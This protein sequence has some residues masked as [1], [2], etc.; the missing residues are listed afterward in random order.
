L[1][2]LLVAAINPEGPGRDLKIVI[3][4]DAASIISTI[5][6]S[7]PAILDD[8]KKSLLD[9][10]RDNKLS[11]SDTPQLILTIQPLYH[12]MCGLNEFAPDIQSNAEI[13]AMV[14]KI[15]THFLILEDQICC[16]NMDKAL[17]LTQFDDLIDL[18]VDLLTPIPAIKLKGCFFAFLCK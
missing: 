10:T 1:A 4:K 11:A 3:S 15:I 8:I 7:R 5:A 12:F 9:V 17:L 16:D 14:F 13:C 18:C 2:A 6:A